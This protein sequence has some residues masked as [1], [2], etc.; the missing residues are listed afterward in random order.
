MPG[1]VLAV[2]VALGDEVEEGEVLLVVEAMKM[3]HAL[4]APFA[5]TVPT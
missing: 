5:G 4:A 1:A 2:R 3:E